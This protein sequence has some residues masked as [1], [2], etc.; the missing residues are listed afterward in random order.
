MDQHWS[1]D[2]WLRNT[3]LAYIPKSVLIH[4][5]NTIWHDRLNI[6]TKA[7]KSQFSAQNLSLLQAIILT[8]LELILPYKQLN[9]RAHVI[10]RADDPF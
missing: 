9:V 5:R 7:E 8:Y 3:A 6:G 4:T 1:A 10:K 2:R